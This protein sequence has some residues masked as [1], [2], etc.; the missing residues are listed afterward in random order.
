MLSCEEQHS[1][2]TVGALCTNV[3]DAFMCSPI[4]LSV[5]WL[6]FIRV[7]DTPAISSDVMKDPHI[8]LATTTPRLSVTI[9]IHL[10]TFW[11]LTGTIKETST[12]KL[13]MVMPCSSSQG[14][15]YSSYPNRWWPL[16][17]SQPS[18][19]KTERQGCLHTRPHCLLCQRQ[20]T[21]MLLSNLKKMAAYIKSE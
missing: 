18:P 7:S 20:K 2:F 5:S 4:S 21:H 12:I 9:E 1:H 13:V 17:W 8:T 11:Y 3:R 19:G 10:I 16:L 14:S 15:P 6:T